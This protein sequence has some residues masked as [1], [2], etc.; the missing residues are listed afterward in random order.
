V[1]IN[2]RAVELYD[3]ILNLKSKIAIFDNFAHQK[4]KSS[5]LFEVM[6]EHDFIEVMENKNY[7]N[8]PS[9]ESMSNY[10]IDCCED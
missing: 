4:M 2:I 7:D 1:Q 9:E 3:H 6:S 8:N 10:P 5:I